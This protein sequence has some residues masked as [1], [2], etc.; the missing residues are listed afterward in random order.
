MSI[1]EMLEGCTAISA[2]E[3]GKKTSVQL[4]L[5]Y[6][7]HSGCCSQRCPGQPIVR[8]RKCRVCHGLDLGHLPAG[9]PWV[10]YIIY[11]II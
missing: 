3:E 9:C 1:G 8:S 10:G 11:L 2:E 7:L 5:T 4:D 6:H